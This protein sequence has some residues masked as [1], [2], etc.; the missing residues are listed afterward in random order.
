MDNSVHEILLVYFLIQEQN[1]NNSV[2]LFLL[3]HQRQ[4]R[5]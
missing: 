2:Q 4:K 5:L 1:L 3:I